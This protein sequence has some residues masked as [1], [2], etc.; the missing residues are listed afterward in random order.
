MSRF[1]LRSSV[2]ILCVALTAVLTATF[3]QMR[4][5]QIV[6]LALGLIIGLAIYWFSRHRAQRQQIDPDLLNLFENWGRDAK[7]N[8]RTRERIGPR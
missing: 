2:V 6:L 7:K 1:D 5:S 8:C 3:F 4:H